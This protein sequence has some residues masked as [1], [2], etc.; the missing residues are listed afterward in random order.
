M[1]AVSYH[2]IRWCPLKR[3][4]YKFDAIQFDYEC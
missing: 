3:V 1:Q 4:E 2:C